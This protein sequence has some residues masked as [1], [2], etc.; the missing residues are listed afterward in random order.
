M[1]RKPLSSFIMGFLLMLGGIPDAIAQHY[2]SNQL[3]SI[4]ERTGVDCRRGEG[5]HYHAAQWNGQPVSI[6]VRQGE[7]VHIGY[8]LFTPWQRTML[9]EAQCNF[10][11]RLALTAD[12]PDFHGKSFSRFMLEEKVTFE[13]G[14]AAALK[15]F[16]TDTNLLFQTTLV[17]GKRHVCNWYRGQQ[18]IVTLSYPADYHLIVGT[19]LE[20]AE[21]RLPKAC[22]APVPTSNLP[23]PTSDLQPPTSNLQR[24]DGGE[25]VL[26]VLTG[27]I[28]KLPE[29]NSN[30]YYVRDPE[31]E[32]QLLYSKDF[33]LESM[34]NL[35]TGT[36][37]ATDIELEVLLVKYGFRTET[38]HVPMRQW[39]AWCLAE[40]CRPYYGVI[41]LQGA[42]ATASLVMHN[43]QLGYIHLM[44]L[45]FDTALIA[46]RR[47]T[48]R[49][50]LNS[51]VPMSNVKALFKEGS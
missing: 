27:D 50:R 25:A 45:T 2:A 24:V 3:R 23:P 49:A 16:C 32:F 41:S 4:A 28:Y 47:G 21:D 8:S 19:T 15:T 14:S 1:L 12:L 20:E 18:R 35:A 44:R 51:Y 13:K 36:E 48:I 34:A 5:V 37:I 33:P 10:I 29:L 30:R 22:L 9:P 39:V 6:V 31:E 46:H 40:G 42:T 43:E 26:Y 11:E 7:V 17:D 38:F